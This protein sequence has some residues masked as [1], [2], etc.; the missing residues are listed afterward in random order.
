MAASTLNELFIVHHTHM[1]VG[2]TDLAGEVRNQHLG[3]LDQVLELCRGNADR[4]ETERF[5]WTCESALLVKDYLEA[6]PKPRREALL[7]ALRDGWIE[8]Q[9]FLTQ[10]LTELASAQELIDALAYA[11]ELGRREGFGVSC[12]MIDDIGGYAGRLPSVM[13]QMNV[14]YLVAGVG[15]FQVHVPWADLPHLFYLRA[16]DGARVLVWNLGIDRNLRP[17]QMTQLAAVYGQAALY[18]ITPFQRALTGAATRGVEIDLANDAVGTSARARFAE[19]EDRLR[20]EHYAYREVL[21]QY[22]GDNRGPDP[23][24]LAVL[25]AVRQR[26]DMPDVRLTT[27]VHFFRHME[28]VCG[29]RI[30]VV[31]GVITD[32]WNLRAN[33]AP[34]T[35]RRH[36]EAQRLLETVEARSALLEAGGPAS[37]RAR[38]A[39]AALNLQLGSDHTCGLSEWGWEKTFSRSSG[40]RDAA[41]DRYRESWQ[42][43]RHYA[44]QALRTLRDLDRVQ[45]QRL[46][47]GV[48]SAGPCVAVWNDTAVATGGECELYLGRGFAPLRALRDPHTGKPVPLQPLGDSRYLLDAPAVPAFG[49]RLLQPEFGPGAP[50]PQMTATPCRLT[51]GGL[52]LLVD[53][54]TGRVRSLR[55]AESATECLDTACAYG[56]GEVVCHDLLGVAYGALQAGMQTDCRLQERPARCAGVEAGPAGPLFS[57]CVTRWLVDGP[58]GPTRIERTLRLYQSAPRLDVLVRVD[59][60]ENE[61]KETLSVAFPWAGQPGTFAF[62]QNLGT[63]EPARDLA[64]GAMQDLFYCQTWAHVWTGDWGVTVVCPDAPLLQFGGMRF[65]QWEDRLPFKATSNHL[66]CQLYHNLLNTDCPVWQDVLDTF[67]F[68]VFFHAGRQ[69]SA[70]E[71]HRLAA[72]S[73]PLRADYLPVGSQGGGRRRLPTLCVEPAAVRVLAVRRREGALCILLENSSPAAVAAAVQPGV[74]V[75]QAALAGLDGTPIDAVRVTVAAARVSVPL[76]PCQVGMLVLRA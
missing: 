31:E 67:R 41:F 44:E 30:P 62:D 42:Q 27:P 65:T 70:G 19:L 68:S 33:P 20:A 51:G 18:L 55:H 28:K 13:A 22:G 34:G 5:Y 74:R 54:A 59:K 17:Q 25:N 53:G 60:P 64:P 52:E 23:D 49:L 61:N 36:R 56:L 57:S 10:P 45:R 35:L 73:R 6:R 75:R 2:Y 47:T 15:A 48:A 46:A 3:H 38:L 14:P 63:I 1:D 69:P 7:Q 8:L 71:R 4:P 29:E 58:R 32:P 9:A 11:C 26:A 76:Q 39:D 21:L 37:Q 72:A 40:C 16:A 12:G 50:A 43:K 24:L 66:L